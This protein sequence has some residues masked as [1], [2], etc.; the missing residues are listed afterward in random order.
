MRSYG[1]SRVVLSIRLVV[2]NPGFHAKFHGI[3]AYYQASYRREGQA[4]SGQPGYVIH[5]AGPNARVNIN[6]TDSS[7]NVV[8]YQPQELVQLA[9]E[10]VTLR[11]ELV[12]L[13]HNAE[14]FVAIG[15]VSQAEIAAKAGDSSKLGNVLSTLGAGG[16]WVL[17]VAKEIGVKLVAEVL[18][19]HLGLPP[20]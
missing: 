14:D 12:K 13:A 3:P 8:N 15:V 16:R 11:E 5:M 18:K 1:N 2:I 6:S 20:G 17:D 10:F 4:Q 9:H 7:T 19:S